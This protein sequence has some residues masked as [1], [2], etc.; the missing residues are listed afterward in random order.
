MTD[1]E[2]IEKAWG[3]LASYT[4][5]ERPNASEVNDLGF[6]LESR[7]AQPERQWIGLTDEEMEGLYESATYMDKTDCI[8]LL[9][10]AADKLKE[11]NA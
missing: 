6:I 11:K 8:H 9:T 2:L 7:L 10:L 4:V 5:G 1:R 3:Y